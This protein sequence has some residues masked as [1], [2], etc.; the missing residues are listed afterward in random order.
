MTT[1][2]AH[3]DPPVNTVPGAQNVSGASLTFSA[4]NGNALS[5]AD[6]DAGGSDI[7]VQLSVLGGT[8]TLGSTAGLTTV[9]GDGTAVVTATGLLAALNSALDGT[10][11][12][13]APATTSDTLSVTSNDQQH[14]SGRSSNRR[15]YRHNQQ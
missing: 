6:A 1:L 14:R 11:Y 15:R 5:V 2:S 12:T 4:V 13:P 7:Q 8:L 3:N 10:V 9:T